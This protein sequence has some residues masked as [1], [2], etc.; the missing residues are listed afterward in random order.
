MP[1]ATAAVTS[2]RDLLDITGAVTSARRRRHNW[3]GAW[4]L[5]GPALPLAAALGLLA[6]TA[7]AVFGG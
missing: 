3:R 6:G 2:A 5:Y 1:A 4:S 7:L